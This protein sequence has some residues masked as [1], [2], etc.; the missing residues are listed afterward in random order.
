MEGRKRRDEKKEGGGRDI[1][2]KE[3]RKRRDDKK[4]RRRKRY[5]IEERKMKDDKKGRRRKRYE[6]E[7]RK[8]RMIS[9]E[10]EGENGRKGRSS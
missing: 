1:R 4:G 5:E 2:L 8:R 6:N 10:A 7:G 9:R 3:G